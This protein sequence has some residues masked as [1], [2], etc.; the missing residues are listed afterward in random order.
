MAKHTFDCNISGVDFKFSISDEDASR[1][2]PESI[3]EYTDVMKKLID[4]SSRVMQKE[5]M[6]GVADIESLASRYAFHP[7]A[8]QIEN[9]KKMLNRYCGKGVFGDQV[10]LGKTIEALMTAHVMFESGSI[11]NA[12]LVVGKKTIS[13][14]VK[15]I[16]TKFP[17]VFKI[18]I[19]SIALKSE[20][21]KKEIG[22]GSIRNI[23][24][25]MPRAVEIISDTARMS[26]A[27]SAL[28]D[29]MARDNERRDGIFRLYIAT[30]GMLESSAKILEGMRAADESRKNL[31]EPPTESHREA[32]SKFIKG[33]RALSADNADAYEN[34]FSGASIELK[35]ERKSFDVFTKEDIIELEYL[36]TLSLFINE[37]KGVRAQIGSGSLRVMDRLRRQGNIDAIDTRLAAL[38]AEEDRLKGELQSAKEV[39]SLFEGERIIDLLMIDEIHK[40]YSERGAGRVVESMSSFLSDIEKKFCVLISAT[41]VRSRLDDIFEL[42]H[43][44]NPKMFGVGRQTDAKE[45][46]YETLC[47]IPRT[48]TGDGVY[49]FPLASMVCDEQ[50]RLSDEKIKVF[51]GLVNSFFTRKRIDDVSGDMRGIYGKAYGSLTDDEKRVITALTRRIIDKRAVSFLKRGV[52]DKFEDCVACAEDEMRRWRATAG[53]NADSAFRKADGNVNTNRRRHFFSCIDATAIELITVIDELTF[54][55]AQGAAE[56]GSFLENELGNTNIL[57]KRSI[58]DLYRQFRVRD[59]KTNWDSERMLDEQIKEFLSSGTLLI[60]IKRLLYSMVNWQRRKKY[61]VAFLPNEPYESGYASDEERLAEMGR[62]VFKSLLEAVDKEKKTASGGRF[63]SKY[64]FDTNAD[65]DFLYSLLLDSVLAYES[66]DTAG[67]G[68]IRI[69]EQIM[70]G[71]KEVGDDLIKRLFPSY[72]VMLGDAGR[73]VCLLSDGTSAPYGDGGAGEDADTDDELKSGEVINRFAFAVSTDQ[74]GINLQQ[75]KTFVFF[76]LDGERGALLNPVDIE[77][78]VGRI[79]RT[80]QVKNCRILTIIDYHRSL[81]S[82][83]KNERYTREFLEW[84]YTDIL[85]D[86]N[87]LDLYGNRTPDI[88][89]IEPIVCDCIRFT[90]RKNKDRRDHT[91]KGFAELAYECYNYDEQRGG[92]LMK[93]VLKRLIRSLCR[94]RGFGKSM[95]MLKSSQAQ[96]FRKRRKA[97]RMRLSQRG[98]K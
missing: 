66:R 79:H 21:N 15:E 69:R 39:R 17:G 4:A 96:S 19:P 56:N 14:W 18:I 51:L 91:A 86:P 27:F 65:D 44:S 32:I 71:V 94:Y 53:K 36:N 26:D 63:I 24:K 62:N 48:A 46:F 80:G 87:G 95:R 47:R 82:D 12:L 34:Y 58:V 77:Q 52:D 81:M 13:G 75:Y 45:Y 33:L 22:L 35:K 55:R 6:F 97:R 60:R 8:Y 31:E 57:I 88:A 98:A 30:E 25:T 2:Q 49:A 67:K 28:I 84:Y 54:L 5:D 74:A 16:L 70:R 9:V 37:L 85:S 59:G 29:K 43:M 7:F 41:P 40:L 11:R 89:F 38:C 73:S 78:W 50:G 42:V 10:G 64:G 68:K 93:S 90:L 23:A 3:R 72:S 92:D 76:Q 83:S 1:I 61:G 20:P